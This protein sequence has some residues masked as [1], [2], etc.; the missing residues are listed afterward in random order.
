MYNYVHCMNYLCCNPIQEIFLLRYTIHVGVFK[1]NISSVI[2][3]II[4]KTCA[5]LNETKVNLW[6]IVLNSLAQPIYHKRER[7]LC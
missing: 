6:I 2:Y 3:I 5:F 4:Y 1:F 7:K